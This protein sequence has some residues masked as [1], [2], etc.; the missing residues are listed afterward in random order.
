M[1]DM[2]A[3]CGPAP[4]GFLVGLALSTG[5]SFGYGGRAAHA[6]VCTGAVR[7]ITARNDDIGGGNAA[8]TNLSILAANVSDGA[9]GELYDI[10]VIEGHIRPMA[11]PPY[12][13]EAANLITLT[14]GATD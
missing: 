6:G 13:A 1:Q 2:R 9:V 4:N 10:E 8:R 14:L 3:R 7:V 5:L 11:V 12:S